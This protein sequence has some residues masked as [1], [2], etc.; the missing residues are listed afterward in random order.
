MRLL[1]ISFCLLFV[2]C[3]TE[4]LPHPDALSEEGGREVVCVPVTI[5][6]G[7]DWSI[8]G[9]GVT[10]AAP[11][12]GN[13][14]PSKWVDGTADMAG[15]AYQVR[16]VAYRR[17]DRNDLREDSLSDKQP[18]PDDVT[19]FVYDAQNDTVISVSP[20]TDAGG[21]AI[22]YDDFGI[23]HIHYV[24]TSQLKKT[25]GYEY[26]VVAYAYDAAKA[27]R[28][29]STGLSVL[30]SAGEQNWVSL[31]TSLPY[32]EA[33]LSLRVADASGSWSDYSNGWN[34][35]ANSVSGNV[36][37]CPQLF[38]GYIQSSGTGGKTITF[39]EQNSEGTYVKTVPL[40]GT[41]YRAVAKVVVDIE[42]DAVADFDEYK[43]ASTEY[44]IQSLCLMAQ[45]TL[46]DATLRLMDNYPTDRVME[47]MSPYGTLCSSAGLY[48]G[49]DFVSTGVTKKGQTYPAL[50]LSAYILPT[51]T[52]L[53]LRALH[54][55][56]SYRSW[57]FQIKAGNTET[58]DTATGVISVD[59]LDNQFVLRR[60]H[61]YYITI[62]KSAQY[63]NNYNHVFF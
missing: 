38:Y 60:N 3:Q 28:F 21:S 36:V 40:T 9:E 22:Y 14:N 26:R 46:R 25:Y 57:N 16:L 52:R 33:C 34:G 61:V 62:P 5:D 32:G 2:A 42:Y 1:P 54:T 6:M 44:S 53:G 7:S 10:R 51:C 24:G 27:S 29:A 4:D 50:T 12:G 58:Y 31:D 20:A 17:E 47:A 55:G 19:G 13:T 41:L 35:S 15:G 63:F 56:G 45:N 43:V 8:D 37:S 18:W 39:A 23:S 59:V 48:T 11:P 30:S 49:L